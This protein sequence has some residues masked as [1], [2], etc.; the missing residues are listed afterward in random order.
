MKKTLSVFLAF[1]ILFC[2]QIP[3][4]AEKSEINSAGDF[5]LVFEEDFE[6][7]VLN[8]KKWKTNT[9]TEVVSKPNKEGSQNLA[10]ELKNVWETVEKPDG[11][12]ENTCY[13]SQ[14]NILNASAR[15]PIN[16]RFIYEYDIMYGDDIEKM[17]AAPSMYMYCNDNSTLYGEGLGALTYT[18]N[19]D[20]T[21]VLSA[22]GVSETKKTAKMVVNSNKWY[23][24]RLD[25][26]VSGNTYSVYVN[27]EPLV[28]DDG[29]SNFDLY[30]YNS[31]RNKNI[32]L[33]TSAEYA[34]KGGYVAPLFQTSRWHSTNMTFWIDNIKCYTEFENIIS[35]GVSMY[36]KSHV[37]YKNG[38]RIFLE[39]VP[40]ENDNELYLPLE[41]V[42]AVF[43]KDSETIVSNANPSS[44]QIKDNKTYIEANS[45][46]NLME[47]KIY[48]SDGFVFL[49]DD[50]DKVAGAD[51]ETLTEIIRMTKYQRPSGD[52]I[53]NAVVSAHPNKN[54]PRINATAESFEYLKELNL[55]D[56]FA[57]K[58]IARRL[59]ETNAMLNTTPV[60][61]AFESGS[62]RFVDDHVVLNRIE[63]LT[64]FYK[65]TGEEKY[66][67]R[68]WKEIECVANYTDW[69]PQHYLDTAVYTEAFSYAY[70]RL[71]D[72]LAEDQKELM[73]TTIVEKS[74]KVALGIYR[75]GWD[76]EAIE[77]LNPR[78]S[79]KTSP[80][81]WNIHCNL[82]TLMGCFAICDDV[83]SDTLENIIKPVMEYAFRSLEVHLDEWAPDGAWQEG[84]GYGQA[85]L[86]MDVRLLDLLETALGKTYG[87]DNIRGMMEA[88]YFMH[89][90]QGPCGT[91]NYSD[92]DQN[93]TPPFNFSFYYAK[94]LG[95][96]GLGAKRKEYI[97]SQNYSSVT[98]LELLWYTPESCEEN[99]AMGETDKY[100]RRG[101]VAT[102]RTSW[103]DNTMFAGFLAG[104]N[105]AGHSQLDIG[106][107]VLDYR[108][109]RWATDLGYDQ[110]SYTTLGDHQT[111]PARAEGH[112]T[113]VIDPTAYGV[114]PDE[115]GWGIFKEDNFDDVE[116][117]DYPP[118]YSINESTNVNGKTGKV[119]VEAVPTASNPENRAVRMNC[120]A[121]GWDELN[122]QCYVQL[123]FSEPYPSNGIKIKF[124]IMPEKVTNTISGGTMYGHDSN[125]N[126]NHVQ[127]V[128]FD[129]NGNI[130]ARK[131]SEV[132]AVQSY[133]MNQWYEVCISIDFTSQTYDLYVNGALLCDNYNYGVDILTL[134]NYRWQFSGY[135]TKAVLDDIRFSAHPNDSDSVKTSI[136][137]YDQNK[138]A[139]TY[140]D[141]FQ[142]SQTSAYAITDMTDAYKDL[143]QSAKR[144]VYLDKYR[145]VFVVKD[146]IEAKEKSDIYWFSHSAIAD[147]DIKVCEDGKSVILTSKKN[148]SRMWVQLLSNVNARFEIFDAAPLPGSPN[149]TGQT[150][151]KNYQKF[152]LKL[153]G[154][155]EADIAVAYIPLRDGADA[156]EYIPYVASLD[157]WELTGD[158]LADVQADVSLPY[159][160]YDSDSKPVTSAKN[161]NLTYRAS[162]LNRTDTQK[163]IHLVIAS[164]NT[165]TNTMT[166]LKVF[167]VSLE[168]GVV[169]PVSKEINSL[170]EADDNMAVK[171]F[172]IEDI[173][174]M[175]MLPEESL[176][177][178]SAVTVQ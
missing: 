176:M 160:F 75:G 152:G 146:E 41:Y 144:G 90:M 131:G 5:V 65:L 3:S 35:N 137:R 21:G 106:T 105:T 72:W 163:T 7:G 20:G 156:P 55:T 40:F 70:D 80:F 42:S 130:N 85:T 31:D 73:R 58:S 9:R 161:T 33:E 171:A 64:L 44:L 126:L 6:S 89:Y 170:F 115:D 141:R 53:Y 123:P 12:T 104:D 71:Y 52:E 177:P 134:S 88:A 68:A 87:Y 84:P 50:A 166:G 129:K 4:F 167:D 178:Y 122:A 49:G 113:I 93:K 168:A 111:Y 14:L 74:L 82:G 162:I 99:F 92:S 66:A 119:R 173:S 140:I 142:S 34:E 103:D 28:C 16:N 98:P 165:L 135:E 51:D 61:Q 8:S 145:N 102:M 59:S 172:Y 47:Q 96:S 94:H 138:N 121:E 136:R 153:E 26:N 120:P 127:F 79:W 118:G 62:I 48:I 132:V 154:V 27:D 91:F 18:S 29:S 37:S 117:G 1:L 67:E 147:V 78:T 107:Y 139:I 128:N 158:A 159:G 150:K 83:D 32:T 174:S 149:P 124:K 157:K 56:E 30:N 175:K 155:R 114:N 63:C 10:A 25:V 39:D 23:S 77:A 95:E 143:A 164:Y 15:Y 43:E 69:N 112:N 13:N 54:H 76:D 45:A 22:T 19:N 110:L 24:I 38:E 116:I 100:F 148:N 109:V 11:T 81:N 46:A 101:E 97:I 169:T 86:T 36:A 151:M 17:T 108:G 57:K 2:V 125:G 133:N 60:K